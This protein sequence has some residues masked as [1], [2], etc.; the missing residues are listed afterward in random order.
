MPVIKSWALVVGINHYPERAGQT[1][2]QGA[3]ADA[4]DFAD[5]ALSDNGG[6]VS[7]SLGSKAENSS[8]G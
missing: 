2:L 8:L 1:P 7:P 6:A 5:W 3:V 4:V